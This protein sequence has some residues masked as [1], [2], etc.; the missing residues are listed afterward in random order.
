MKTGN[1][2]FEE[3]QMKRVSTSAVRNQMCESARGELRTHRYKPLL[4]PDLSYVPP[5][6]AGMPNN[7]AP[8]QRKLAFGGRVPAL[9]QNSGTMQLSARPMRLS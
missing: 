6:T 3:N 1:K 2:C 4:F 9:P 7:G 5:D 8:D